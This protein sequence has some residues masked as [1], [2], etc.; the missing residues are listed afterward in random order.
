MKY[1]IIGAS[2][3]G[4]AC[5]ESIR[6]TDKSGE[7]TVFTKESSLPYSRPSI[8]YYLKG[9]V[10]SSDMLLHPAAYYRAKNI[11]ILTNTPVTAIDRKRKVLRAGRKTYP[12]D[13]LCIC[14]G[15]KPFVPPVKNAQ[16]KANALTFLDIAAAKQ[17]KAKA[18]KNT[19][20][21]V[22]GAGLIGMKA[23]EGLSKI[24]KSVDVVE[25]AEFIL[26]S[27][28]DKSAA[29]MVK[30]HVEAS[31]NIRFY[32]GDTV[33]AAKSRGA[34]ITA[35][36]LGSGREL[37]CDLLVLAVGVRP[38]TSLVEAAGLAVE[39]GIVTDAA[40]MQT[41]DSDIYAAGD[42]ALSLD[43]L[44]SSK[45]II[46]LW[47]NAVKQGKTAG[48]HMAGAPQQAGGAYAVNAIDFFGCRI[49]TCGLIHADTA[50]YFSKVRQAGGSYKKL[51]FCGKQLVGFVL[52]GASDNAGIYTSLIEN[53]VDITT[54]QGDL[55]DTPSV[56]L[57][58]KAARQQRLKGEES[59]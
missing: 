16:G 25:L 6:Q 40:T 8:S 21:V 10:G 56:F 13:K 52:V 12:Y 29:K 23:A 28:L 49:C 3:A 43:M 45:K 1:C 42:C 44:D 39:R 36:T 7:I 32:L 46:A 54:L 55:M 18:G 19:R 38:E 9:A 27:I 53:R 33:A 59:A 50:P 11:T 24:C 37:P 31:S 5:A 22:I 30:A 17:L 2:A 58:N 48:F 41:G 47:G 20:A 4:L 35:V 15:S 51:V 14:T 26:P 57:F 34:H